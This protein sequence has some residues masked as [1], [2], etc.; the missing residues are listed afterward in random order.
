MVKFFVKEHQ[1]IFD[2]VLLP[3]FNVMLRVGISDI[4]ITGMSRKQIHKSWKYI[5]TK[6][7]H[8]SK[9]PAL[10]Y[11]YRLENSTLYHYSLNFYRYFSFDYL[12]IQIAKRQIDK[13]Y[14]IILPLYFARFNW[15]FSFRQMESLNKF[16]LILKRF[17]VLCLSNNYNYK[18]SVH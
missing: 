16:N 6:Y 3:I 11:R 14:Q 1:T 15:H 17:I 9:I 18:K 2:A 7:S 4:K 13:N 10:R 12:W 5:N 8:L